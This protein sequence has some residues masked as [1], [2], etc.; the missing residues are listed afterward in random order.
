MLD[1][2][3]RAFRG[4]LE[5]ILWINLI[6]STVAGG[7]AG[8]Y[9]GKLI[10]YRNAGGY[11]FGG[12]VIGII[13]G[14]LIDIIGGGFITT[15]L[16]IEKNT[17]EQTTLLKKHLGINDIPVD[18]YKKIIDETPEKASEKLKV[19]IE[20]SKNKL[21]IKRL[22]NDFGSALLVNVNI[23][24]KNSFVLENG[25]EKIIDISNGK[26]FIDA[27]FNNDFDKKEFDIDNNGKVFT[28]ITRPSLK[29]ME[30]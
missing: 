17:E 24:G 18:T 29:I 16:S 5:V 28:I 3:K 14:L 8:Y 13:F 2:V 26:H 23:D 4:G 21:A 6:L 9:L 1:F 7:V 27:A 25:E 12:V 22:I 20:D 19:T 15:I 30:V 11:A 10:S